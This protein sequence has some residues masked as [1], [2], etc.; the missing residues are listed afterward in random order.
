MTSSNEFDFLP[1]L[2]RE[3]Q[4]LI[5]LRVMAHKE[6]NGHAIDGLLHDA[7]KTMG[8]STSRPALRAL[9]DQL[10][11]IGVITTRKAN[12]CVVAS[13]TER[14]ERAAAGEERVEGVARFFAE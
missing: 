4:A 3:Y 8:L 12:D 14:G 2:R 9:L 13:L 10:E 7:L 1:K 5:I 11:Q 6:C